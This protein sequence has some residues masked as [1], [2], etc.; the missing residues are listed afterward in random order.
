MTQ[1]LSDILPYFVSILTGVAAWIAGRSKQRNDFISDLQKSID[2]LSD[3]NKTLLQELINLRGENTNMRANQQEMQV[4]LTYLR[5]E[6]REL[7]EHV[8]ELTELI[9]ANGLTVKRK[10]T[11]KQETNDEKTTIN[12]ADDA[13][14]AN[15]SRVQGSST[16]SSARDPTD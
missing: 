13:T 3:K 9:T 11:K 10:R 2:L 4:S 15:S 5:R 8:Q 16:T 14:H 6:N 12:D 7:R 1:L